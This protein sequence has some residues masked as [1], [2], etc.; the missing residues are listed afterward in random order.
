M[1]PAE[2]AKVLPALELGEAVRRHPILAQLAR[3]SPATAHMAPPN[4]YIKAIAPS[5]GA[6]KAS[7]SPKR[8]NGDK[9]DGGA[10]QAKGKGRAVDS[11]LR[12][13]ILALGGDE[14][15]F[16]LL[17]GVESESEVEGD[18]EGEV[19]LLRPGWILVRS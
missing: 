13:E 11:V 16:E 2:S 15:D 1:S 18:E 12:D 14:A 8:K 9:K 5:A 3:C 4:P 7:A 6:S 19:R 10:A 17:E